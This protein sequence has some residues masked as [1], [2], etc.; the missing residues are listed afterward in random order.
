MYIIRNGKVEIG[1]WP[2][3]RKAVEAAMADLGIAKLE[4]GS[5]PPDVWNIGVATAV[6]FQEQNKLHCSKCRKPLDQ[7]DDIRCL[8]CRAVYC[9]HCAK[10]HFWPQGR[11]QGDHHG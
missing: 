11:P 5:I 3:Y 4:S 2:P 9:P 1:Y 8:D 6:Q 10:E 7:G